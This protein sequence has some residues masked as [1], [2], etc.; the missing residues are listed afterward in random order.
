MAR[1]TH[2]IVV[3]A[4][5]VLDAGGCPHGPLWEFCS[6]QLSVITTIRSCDPRYNSGDAIRVFD[7]QFIR[8]Q[9]VGIQ[10]TTRKS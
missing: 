6:V 2:A 3:D 5:D 7:L 1:S 4:P 9:G 10:K 8:W